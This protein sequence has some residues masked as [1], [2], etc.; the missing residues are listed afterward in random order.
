MRLWEVYSLLYYVSQSALFRLLSRPCGNDLKPE[1]TRYTLWNHLPLTHFPQPL[2]PLPLTYESVPPG[3][4][5]HLFF[6]TPG[7]V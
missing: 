5:D 6:Q 2:L 4:T 3:F 7:G 1:D